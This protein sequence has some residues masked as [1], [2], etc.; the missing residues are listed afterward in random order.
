M[1]RGGASS[2]GGATAHDN[3]E[4]ERVD[5]DGRE[6]KDGSHRRHGGHSAPSVNAA[7][8][9]RGGGFAGGS[10]G[11]RGGKDEEESS[12][13]GDWAGMLAE[14]GVVTARSEVV[15]PHKAL[16]VWYHDAAPETSSEG[17]STF[18]VR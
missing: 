11:A 2:R 13:E 18:F 17:A 16:E 3:G 14:W 12:K 10:G 4:S 15:V 6:G 1:T 5:R 9:S 8:G 7:V